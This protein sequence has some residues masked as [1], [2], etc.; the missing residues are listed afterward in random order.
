MSMNTRLLFLAS[1]FI[2]GCHPSARQEQQYAAYFNKIIDSA[3]QL[4]PMHPAAAFYYVDSAYAS[5]PP[6]GPIDLY[7]KYDFKREYF[8][9]VKLD[10]SKA[11]VYMDSAMAIFHD[12]D[13]RDTNPELYANALNLKGDILTQQKDYKDAY[14]FYYEGKTVIENAHDT[15][16]FF[17]YLDRLGLSCYNQGLYAQAVN[18]FGQSFSSLSHCSDNNEFTRFV[19]QQRDL[20]NIGEAYTTLHKNDS[21]LYYYDSTLRYLD[22]NKAKFITNISRYHYVETAI[23]VVYGGKGDAAY[24]HGD[25]ALAEALYIKCIGINH[26]PDHD[27]QYAEFTEAQLAKVYLADNQLD[28]AEATLKDLRSAL[29]SFP[30][31]AAEVDYLEQLWHFYDQSGKPQEAFQSLLAFHTLKDSVENGGK[32]IADDEMKSE[33]QHISEENQLTLLQKQNQLKN[34]VLL[35]AVVF[36]LMAIAIIFLVEQNAR[37]SKKHVAKLTQLNRRISVQNEQ[38]RT[39]LGAL[40]QSHQENT[41]LMKVMAHDLRNPIGASSSLASLLLE[42][43]DMNEEHR[44]MLELIRSSS[45]SSLKMITDLLQSN[46]SNEHLVKEPTDLRELLQ[47]C[48]EQLRFKAEEKIQTI[49]LDADPIV[50]DINRE[51]IWRVLSNLITN[52]IKFSP[53]GAE[54]RVNMHRTPTGAQISVGDQGMGI[55]QALRDKIFDSFT[56]S[57]RSGT[58]G[59]ESFGL[60]LSISKQIIEAHEGRIWFES[61]EGKGTTFFINLPG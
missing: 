25:T 8:Q 50:L 30:S 58:S 26:L 23:G 27:K 19:Y 12:R 18:Y 42:D 61:E 44:H 46:Q 2:Y 29:D 9:N 39:A 22:R 48:A 52:A 28:K 33:L 38:M 36:A 3:G 11:M 35:V 41:R 16:V 31:Q 45:E 4:E 1:I 7:R 15:C 51:K 60:G 32:P 13:I 5:G 37:R 17:Q 40:E 57:R 59:E 47:Y 24:A 55:P 14:H 53:S 34:A 49:H 43:S 6:P 21:A 56:E 10:D 54:I 20:A